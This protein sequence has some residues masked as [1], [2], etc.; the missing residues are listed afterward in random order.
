M[1]NFID[2]TSSSKGT[3]LNRANMMAVQGFADSTITYGKDGDGN[4]T[5]QVYNPDGSVRHITLK[6][7]GA[8]EWL[9]ASVGSFKFRSYFDDFG[10]LREETINE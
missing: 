6:D 2:G 10:T 4:D 1:V 7:D 5:I 3:P 9:D 8:E